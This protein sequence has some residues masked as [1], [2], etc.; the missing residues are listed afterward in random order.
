MWWIKIEKVIQL[1]TKG[2]PNKTQHTQRGVA[3]SAKRKSL[4]RGLIDH[5]NASVAATRGW[6]HTHTQTDVTSSRTRSPRGRRGFRIPFLCGDGFLVIHQISP[7]LVNL[8]VTALQQLQLALFQ[9]VV[10]L[11]Q[12]LQLRAQ[13]EHIVLERLALC[14]LRPELSRLLRQLSHLVRCRVFCILGL[15]EFPFVLFELLTQLSE[16][17]AANVVRNAQF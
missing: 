9:L 10:L 7:Q 1:K 12:L 15:H 14:R 5:R 6:A 8:L 3:L 17:F 16:L 11:L 13:S 4:P 2:T